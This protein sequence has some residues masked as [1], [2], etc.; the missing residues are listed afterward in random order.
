MRA[1]K[2]LIILATLLISIFLISSCKSKKAI[3]T[4]SEGV[5]KAKTHNEVVEDILSNGLQYERITTKGNVTLK[6]IKAPATFKIIKDEILQAS[7]GMPIFG[8]E[9]ARLDITPNMIRIIDRRGKQYAEADL[10][11]TDLSALTAFNFHNLQALLTNQLFLAGKKDIGHKDFN[12]FSIGTEDNHY[13]LEAKDGSNIKYRFSVNTNERI[14][15]TLISLP[16]KK[17][18]LLWQYDQFI[19]DAPHIYPTDMKANLAI[20]NKRIVFDISYP[21]LNINTD[22]KVDTSVSSKYKKVDIVDLLETYIKIK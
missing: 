14:T 9:I 3:I 7:I 15:S 1:Y 20:K 2:H 12:R 17:I 18:S 22:F 11:N 4:D 21:N 16:S 10:N 6:G 13:L 19:E 5:L 8:G